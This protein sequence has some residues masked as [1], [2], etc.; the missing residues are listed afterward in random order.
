MKKQYAVTQVCQITLTRYE[1]EQ[2]IV[3]NLLSRGG[4]PSYDF[5]RTHPIC[6]WDEKGDLSVRFVQGAVT[7]PEPER[8]LSLRPQPTVAE[9]EKVLDERKKKS[10][11]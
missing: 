8:W 9:L 7:S 4:D 3:E 10:A 1:I 11:A 2:I 5:S 6:V